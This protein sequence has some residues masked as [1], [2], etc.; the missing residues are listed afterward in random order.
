MPKATNVAGRMR[1][2]GN[3]Y[4]SW[5]DSR[6]GWRYTLLKS[7]QVDN[8]VKYARWH[9]YVEGWDNEQGDT[10]VAELLPGLVSSPGVQFDQ[11]I[12]PTWEAFL[13]WARGS[14]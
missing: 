3:A 1:N 6:S 9:T 8:G 7:Y 10:Y 4:A 14:A 2:R 11:S 13:E 5:T 12:W